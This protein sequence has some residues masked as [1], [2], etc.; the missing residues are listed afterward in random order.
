[1]DVSGLRDVPDCETARYPDF[2]P[3]NVLSACDLS[4]GLLAR[5]CC[6]LIQIH[7]FRLVLRLYEGATEGLKLYPETAKLSFTRSRCVVCEQCIP[8]CPVEAI[9]S[10][11]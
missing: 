1:M 9:S 8:T 5:D 6:G 2:P 3:S 10:N 7:A 11:L 4:I